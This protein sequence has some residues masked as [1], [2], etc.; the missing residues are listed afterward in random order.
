MKDKRSFKERGITLIALVITIVV[1]LI[2]AGVTINA[3]FS[4]SG[5]IKKAQQAQNK[6]NESV[7]KDM[8]QINAVENWMNSYTN[9]T[10]STKPS[11]P[12]GGEISGIIDIPNASA[13]KGN[14]KISTVK[15]D[16]YYV[17]L[18]RIVEKLNGTSRTSTVKAAFGEDLPS[19]TNLYGQEGIK[20][21]N[22][23]LDDYKFLSP[24]L[25]IKIDY[26]ATEDN[27]VKITFVANNMTDNMTVDILYYCNEH[28]WEVIEGEKISGNQVEGYL[29]SS[30][31]GIPGALIYKVSN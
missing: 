2:L 26:T 18:Q 15:E 31:A 1:L 5:I 29:H 16:M 23:D 30:G 10:D 24:V 4:D 21:K 19:S 13:D 3:V 8:E 27:P 9:T 22:I 7:Q 12:G 6:A 14:V 25:D 11:T 28:G 17:D 20:R